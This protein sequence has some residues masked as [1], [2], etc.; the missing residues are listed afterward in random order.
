MCPACEFGGVGFHTY[1]PEC[2]Y[3]I[4]KA[5]NCGVCGKFVSPNQTWCNHCF[6]TEADYEA[7]AEAEAREMEAA[8][9]R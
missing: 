2:V 5:W 1:R 4:P 6:A 3:A 9:V 7:A 8:D